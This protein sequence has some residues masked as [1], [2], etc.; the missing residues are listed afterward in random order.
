LQKKDKL[1]KKEKKSI[2]TALKLVGASYCEEET[3]VS[4]TCEKCDGH[5]LHVNVDKQTKTLSVVAVD[6]KAKKIVIGIRQTKTYVIQSFFKAHEQNGKIELVPY[7]KIKGAKV[8]KGALETFNKHKDFIVE[9]VEILRL[10]YGY[11]VIVT[12]KGHGAAVA[13]I[14]AHDLHVKHIKAELVVFGSPRVGNKKFADKIST[15]VKVI[16]VVNNN[17]PITKLPSKKDGYKHVGPVVKIDKN[18]KP[19]VCKKAED[20]KCSAKNE[21][22]D[23]LDHDYVG[24]HSNQCVY[25]RRKSFEHQIK[26]TKKQLKVLKAKKHNTDDD[27]ENDENDD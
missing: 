5:P 3:L 13:T 25:A 17:D 12:G 27:D 7:K 11:E 22:L 23:I 9:K 20:K 16:R 10:Q 21:Y 2:S 18:H 14:V 8:H 15:D 24:A 19:I 6:K 4:G 1:S 26:A